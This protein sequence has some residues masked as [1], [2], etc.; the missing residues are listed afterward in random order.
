MLIDLA[1]VVAVALVALR[2]TAEQAPLSVSISGLDAYNTFSTI[3]ESSCGSA[4]DTLATLIQNSFNTQQREELLLKLLEEQDV[5]DAMHLTGHG[6][7]LEE[8]IIIAMFGE[9]KPIV[10]VVIY[11]IVNLC[12]L[13]R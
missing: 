5:V 4:T 10:C 8:E 2:A 11:S 1:P 12:S 13:A 7:G 3:L 6:D 9:E